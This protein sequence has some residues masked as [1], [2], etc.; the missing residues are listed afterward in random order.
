MKLE[1]VFMKTRQ[2]V[3]GIDLDVR[4]AC[5]H[6]TSFVTAFSL[7]R[8][9]FFLDGLD[10]DFDAGYVWGWY[11]LQD[12]AKNRY[13][14]DGRVLPPV[15]S[16]GGEQ[17]NYPSDGKNRSKEFISKFNMGYTIDEHHTINISMLTAHG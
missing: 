14:W 5:N 17:N 12:K 3:Q 11:G 15:S 6:S 7:K 1:A 4:E 2:E 10:F 8:K 16:F 9:N 13:D